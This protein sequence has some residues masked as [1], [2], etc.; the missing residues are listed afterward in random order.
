MAERRSL[1]LRVRDVAGRAVKI[2][3]RYLVPIVL[4]IL[5]LLGAAFLIPVYVTSTPSFCN[6][7]HLMQPYVNSWEKSTHNKATCVSCHVK[8]GLWNLVVNQVVVSKN[9]YLNFF[10]K[11]GM[12]AEIGSATNEN[13][14]R[15]NCHSTNRE[16]S[17]SGDI[18]IPHDLHVNLENMQCKDCHFNVVHTPTGGTPRV[19]MGVCAMCHNG[20]TAPDTCSTCHINPPTAQEAHPTLALDT[21]AAIGKGR[22]QDCYRCHHG[23]LE[24]CVRDGCHTAAFFEQLNLQQQVLERSTP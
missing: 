10:G 19:P 23:N 24:T 6:N 7:C 22:A 20:T 17:S 12:P 14:L 21:H 3:L 5:I 2:R 13:C 18:K 1:R 16:V 8:P 11:A 4:G 9:I 15:A